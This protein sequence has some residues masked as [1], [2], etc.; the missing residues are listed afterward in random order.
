[1][2]VKIIGI[3]VSLFFAGFAVAWGI[4]EAMD[5]TSLISVYSILGL[6]VFVTLGFMVLRTA[7]RAMNKILSRIEE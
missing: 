6:G 5:V 2:K 4:F 1:M 7:T 3:A